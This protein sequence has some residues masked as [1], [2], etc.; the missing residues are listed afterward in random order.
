[1]RNIFN[2]VKVIRIILILK[3]N[4]LIRMGKERKILG[5]IE[6]RINRDMKISK[7]FLRIKIFLK[8]IVPH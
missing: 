8:M 7:L 5:E 4:I 2:L 3:I 1:M 6:R